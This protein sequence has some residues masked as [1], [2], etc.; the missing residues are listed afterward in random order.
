MKR[1]FGWVLRVVASLFALAG[2]AAMPLL[3]ESWEHWRICEENFDGIETALASFD[4]LDAAPVDAIPNGERDHSC[5]DTDDHHA[6]ISRS[7][8]PTGQHSSREHVESFYRDLALRNGWEPLSVGHSADGPTCVV[9]EVD[10]AEVR[11]EVWFDPES[12]NT[13]Y[14]VSVTTWPC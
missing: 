12:E 11:L 5:T 2:L 4:V 7:Y 9:K 8:R 14:I 10:D 1:V 6:S 3:S 13:A